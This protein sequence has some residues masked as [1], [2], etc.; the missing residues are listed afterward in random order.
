M[1]KG[2]FF[3]A[4]LSLFFLLA[5]LAGGI[6]IGKARGIPFV[7]K[8][9]QWT[10]GI[11]SGP[12]P[13]ELTSSLWTMNP[14]LTA[15]D[16]TD[17]P[18]KF[19]A[20]PFLFEGD[21][22]WYLFFEVYNYA[23]EQGDLAVATGDGGRKWSYEG[24]VLDEPFHLSY[25]YVFEW[26]GAQYMIPETFETNSIRL[27]RA[28]EFPTGWEFVRTLVEGREYVDSSILFF[29]DRWWLFASVTS[30]DTL[31]LFHADHL[32]GPW[33]EHPRSPIVAGDLHSA[34]PSGRVLVYEGRP[35]RLT[36]DVAP[37]EGTHEVW[38]FEITTLTPREYEERRV[39][40]KPILG[41]GGS[42]WTEQAMHQLDA[43]RIGERRWIASVDGFGEYWVFGLEY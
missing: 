22:V 32:E 14:V 31:F 27:Y 12:S 7:T 21:S 30:N 5:G 23:T 29:Q 38:A 42:R 24:L 36:M 39:G 43:H 25:P 28:S 13:F 41:A 40:E 1:K 37:P 20:D 26:E 19:V 33:E 17:V 18:A 4:S 2:P 16:V 6:L 35:F 34:R 9:E 3:L 10:I 15:E 11:Y 8:G